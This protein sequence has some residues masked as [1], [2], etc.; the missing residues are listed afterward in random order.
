M[1][2]RAFIRGVIAGPLLGLGLVATGWTASSSIPAQAARSD[3]ILVIDGDATGGKPM[4]LDLAQLK[5]LPA[6]TITTA[7][8]WTEG[9]NRFD[10]VRL[11]DL[12]AYLGAG[13]ATVIAAAVDDYR[14][15][16][17]SEDIRYYD[18]IIAYAMNGK[19][20]PLDDKGP[21]WIIYP[22]SGNFGLQ[23]DLYF[24][25]AVWQLNRLTVQ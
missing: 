12:L 4:A 13:E 15:T 22:F 3:T 23:K 10:G 21:L 1:K 5:T 14:I 7:T 24:A 6:T 2:P 25:R 16:I 20:L 9:E 19:P 8:P 17:P 11:S 18:V